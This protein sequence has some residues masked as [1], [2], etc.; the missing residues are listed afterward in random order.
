MLAAGGMASYVV[1]YRRRMNS[2]QEHLVEEA[3]ALVAGAETGDLEARTQE[4]QELIAEARSS[5]M[6]G[7]P[8]TVGGPRQDTQ[9]PAPAGGPA[10]RSPMPPARGGRQGRGSRSRGP[11][12]WRGDRRWYGDERGWRGDEERGWRGSVGR[13]WYGN[14][15]RGWCGDAERGWRDDAERDWCGGRD[16]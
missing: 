3:E 2:R 13:G 1:V 11:R 10:F 15:E 8:A 5:R 9:A 14:E 12:P 7:A 6:L 4:S 16:A